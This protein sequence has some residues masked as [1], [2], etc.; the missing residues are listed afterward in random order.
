MSIEMVRQQIYE[1]IKRYCQSKGYME[2]QGIN[3]F[4]PH[5]CVAAF[6]MAKD[7]I[8]SGNFD[9]FVAIAPEGHVY[10]YFFEM[11]GAKI[12]EV[13][14]DYPP[15]LIKEVDDLLSISE[16]KVLLIEDDLISGKTLWMVLDVLGRYSPQSVSLYLGHTK[17]VQH[18]HNVPERI[19]RTY[20]AEDYLLPA[21]SGQY[22]AEVESYWNSKRGSKDNG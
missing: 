12:R 18:L 11:L 8:G 19:S 4:I 7:L 17:S 5:D 14:V 13:F 20:L 21:L 6:Q 22:V 2:G 10:S 16:K 1:E 15:K 9:Y 3:N